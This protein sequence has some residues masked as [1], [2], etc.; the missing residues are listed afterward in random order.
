MSLEAFVIDG[1]SLT[2][3]A[4]F[5]A[6]DAPAFAPGALRPDW[7]GGPDV[8]GAVLLE[9]PY[10]DNAVLTLKLRVAQQAT[11]DLA[12]GY[13]GQL[14]DKLGAASRND[15]TGIDL[16]WTPKDW[17]TSFTM[18]VLLGEIN[19]V[20][21]DSRGAD[22]GWLVRSPVL[23]VKLTCR[24]LM[25]GPWLDVFGDSFATDT[26]TPGT[27]YAFDAGAGTLTVSG[28]VLVP[29]STTEKR[30]IHTASPYA[31][32]NARAMIKVTTGASVASGVAGPVVK[33]LGVNDCLVG[34]IAFLGASS[35]VRVVKIDGGA[36]ST[37]ASSAT[38]TAA[39][40]TSY[41]VRVRQEG[42]A[43]TAEY[44]TAV[45]TATSTPAKTVTH[46][47]TGG[48][49]TKFGTGVIGRTGIRFQPAGTDW[50]ADDFTV[51]P[52]VFVSTAAAMEFVVAGVPGDAP[53]EGRLILTDTAAQTRRHV[54]V[55][56]EDDYTSSAAAVIPKAS[57]VTSGFAGI[58]AT[59]ALQSTAAF[60]T[61]T[62]THIGTWRVKLIGAQ[63]SSATVQI[64]LA[65][66]TGDSPYSFTPW[67]S[68]PFSGAE[69]ELDFGVIQIA[70]VERGTQAWDGR[71]EAKATVVGATLSLPN[72]AAALLL[73]PVDR[74]VKARAPFVYRAGVLVARDEFTGRTAGTALNALVAPTG[75][76][77]AT[78][79]TATDFAA[80]DAPTGKETMSRSTTADTGNG[81]D[82]VLGTTVYAATEVGVDVLTTAFDDVNAALYASLLARYVD[83]SN[84]L[85]YS[86]NIRDDGTIAHLV[87][88]KVVAGVSTTLGYSANSVIPS[89][90]TWYSLRML[91]FIS[92]Y[93]VAQLLSDA[94]VI[95]YHVP[96]FD[97]TLVTGGTLDDG[98]I[99]FRDF[100]NA[101]PA[102]TR[103]YDNF[104]GM[105]PVTEPTVIE[106]GKTLVLSHE[107]ALK[108]SA[109][110]GTY[111]ELVPRGGRIWVPNAGRDDLQS[112]FVVKARRFDVDAT[113]DTNLSDSLTAQLSCRPRFRMPRT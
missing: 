70:E 90:N 54:E 61:G 49:A 86:W 58:P 55:G 81:R 35:V 64:R 1:L 111:G 78:S 8:D 28:G 97:S 27:T 89:L 43:V 87:V 75:G 18:V 36:V 51:E 79:G 73:I 84:Y 110:G 92:G 74:Y 94:G 93:G 113:S 50:R 12:A 3:G 38:F 17:T 56:I 69:C 11:A 13:I 6:V 96:F 15:S 105:T 33:R 60:G 59:L 48:D 104:Y 108:E 91:V 102:A 9:D 5:E 31:M 47:L 82:A 41:W 71:V 42:N 67:I 112:R 72:A 29:S 83:A 107:S 57:L 19:G 53:A 77:W 99:G 40:S 20:V 7:V 32:E 22:M 101:S 66:R 25:Y 95:L 98:K 63:V 62:L 68:A 76:T 10:A 26:I 46:T 30:L 109:A 80:A 65:Y 39:T 16:V 100:S 14:A 44:F 4:P 24:A 23:V 2:D 106:S 88:T 52:N 85:L 45:P 37:L 21:M 34:Q 103:Y